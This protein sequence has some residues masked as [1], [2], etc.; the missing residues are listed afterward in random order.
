MKRALLL[1]ALVVASCSDQP[2]PEVGDRITVSGVSNDQP[3]GGKVVEVRGTWVRLG[4]TKRPGDKKD[5]GFWV[6]VSR[7]PV[8]RI[9]D[10][11][12]VDQ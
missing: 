8:I 11:K 6:D 7:F 5:A 1:L 3:Y 4:D 12:T 10:L 9:V 2:M